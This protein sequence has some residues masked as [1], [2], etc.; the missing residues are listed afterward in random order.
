MTITD[1]ETAVRQD[2]NDTKDQRLRS[3]R[4][5]RALALW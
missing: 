4:Y 5:P 1:M 3:H 2:L